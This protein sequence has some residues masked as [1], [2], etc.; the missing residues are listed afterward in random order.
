VAI[1]LYLAGAVVEL[2][3]VAA[4]GRISEKDGGG[5][6]I[7]QLLHHTITCGLACAGRTHVVAPRSA[8]SIA[9]ADSDEKHVLIALSEALVD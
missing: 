9:S 1:F 3:R 2:S 4:C 8:A 7:G 5:R 6:V